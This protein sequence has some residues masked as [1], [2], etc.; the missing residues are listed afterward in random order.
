[1][2]ERDARLEKAVSGKTV[3]I[4]GASEG[5]GEAT[6]RRVAASGGIVLLAARTRERLE[7]VQAD[8]EA[9]GGSASV[10][11]VDMGDTA[12]VE[13]LVAEITDQYG[14]VDVIVNNAGLSIRR[15]LKLSYD[16]FHDFSRTNNVNYLGPVRLL[17]GL[18]PAM[19]ERGEGH[20]INI[21]TI[22]VQAPMPRWAAYTA[23]KAAF[24]YWLRC[25]APELRFRGVATTS[26]YFPLVR[27]RM[28]APTPEYRNA[29]AMSP[30]HAAG[31]ICKAIAKRPRTMSLPWGTGA[32]LLS[33]GSLG[34]G[35]QDRIQAWGYRMTKDSPAAKGKGR[36]AKNEAEPADGPADVFDD[37]D[38]ETFELGEGS[39]P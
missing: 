5:I 25:N 31:W 16:R 8:I 7:E 35:L 10:H 33:S 20:V 6:A 15:S 23:S 34:R 32:E 38:D 3:L 36:F 12:S 18:L 21:S 24:D 26:I 2:S 14:H 22:G 30:E 28:I 9:A 13:K 19:A 37:L 11:V 39:Q 17:L 1:M 29:P 4:T 27:T